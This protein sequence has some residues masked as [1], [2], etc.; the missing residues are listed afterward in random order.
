MGNV[1]QR[2]DDMFTEVARKNA[3]GTLTFGETLIFG[4]YRLMEGKYAGKVVIK[5]PNTKVD[6]KFVCYFANG[7]TW[8]YASDIADVRCERAYPTFNEPFHEV[9][10][11]EATWYN[12]E[13]S[14]P[15]GHQW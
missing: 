9:N 4:F 11:D 2:I 15:Q 14:V 8:V 3:E 13:S 10:R 1:P 7:L 5:T 12:D 6:E